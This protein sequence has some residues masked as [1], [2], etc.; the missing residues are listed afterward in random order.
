MFLNER[1]LSYE[2]FK[3]KVMTEDSKAIKDEKTLKK[4][5]EEY[6]KGF[7]KS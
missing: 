1:M 5:Y 3:S 6:T 7:D 2:E 4:M